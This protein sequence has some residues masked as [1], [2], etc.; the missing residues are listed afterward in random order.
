V[1]IILPLE[2]WLQSPKN[3]KRLKLTGKDVEKVDLS[4]R[5]RPDQPAFKWTCNETILHHCV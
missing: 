4:P 3:K 5:K 1:K 2:C